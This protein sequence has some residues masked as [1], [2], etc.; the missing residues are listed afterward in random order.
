MQSDRTQDSGLRTGCFISYPIGK[1][2][3]DGELPLM[4]SHPFDVKY[5]MFVAIATNRTS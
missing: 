5:S 2:M 1:G 4:A 3:H